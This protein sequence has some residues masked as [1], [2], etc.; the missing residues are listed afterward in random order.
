[1][2]TPQPQKSSKK[3]KGDKGKQ[4]FV[5]DNKEDAKIRTFSL[6]KSERSSDGFKVPQD[7]ET[8][9]YSSM[10]DQYADSK[11]PRRQLIPTIREKPRTS[12][13]EMLRAIT[14]KYGGMELGSG[15]FGQF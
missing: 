8:L 14:Q 10:R 1:M 5:A 7:P 13:V 11:S 3:A 6:Q 12:Q 9:N 2:L 15:S 4:T